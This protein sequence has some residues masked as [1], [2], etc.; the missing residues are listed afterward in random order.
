[1]AGTDDVPLCQRCYDDH[2]TS[3]E[4]C[5][6]IIHRD[7]AYY[8]DDDSDEAYCS[9]CYR[10]HSRRDGI[11]DYYYK[12]DPI[13]YGKGTRYFGVELEVDGV[14]END[15]SAE[16][17]MCIGN[18]KAEHIYCKHDGSLNGGF[19]IVTHPMTLDYHKNIM[20]WRAVLDELKEIG[21]LSHQTSPCGLHI[22]V[23]RDGFG[24]TYQHQEDAIARILF[25]VETHWH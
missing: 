10:T 8:D 18:R 19:E 14:G 4:H 16:D 13:F 22:H 2:Y 1:M 7:D 20:P 25:F 21:Y 24:T 3:C 23:S 11:E 17:V 12:P 15:Y 5:G 6:R 9:S